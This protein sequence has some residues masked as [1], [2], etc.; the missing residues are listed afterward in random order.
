MIEIFAGAAVLCSVAKQLGMKNS[1]AVDKVKKQNACSTIYQLDLLSDRDRQLL[2]QW[3][4]SGLLLWIHLAP[5]CGTASRARDI[6]RFHNDPK[7]L[8]S[9]DWPEGL[10][11]LS[12]KELER[13]SLANR[14][15]EAACDFFLLA[16]SRGVLVTMENPKNSYFW[17]TKW[18]Q[19]LISSVRTFTADFQVCMMGG[20][21]DKWTRLLAN[22]GEIS[23]MNIA[24]DKSHQHAPWGFAFDSEGR[25][26]WATALESQYPKKMCVVLTSIVLEVAASRGLE[27]QAS[28]LSSDKNPLASAVQAQMS[29]DRQPKPSRVPPIV[30]DFSSVAIFLADDVS[31]LPCT[32]MSKLKNPIQLFTHGGQLQDVPANSRLLRISA[33]PELS[34]GG[35][36]EA[37]VEGDGNKKRKVH[38][39]HPLEVAF[40]LPWTWESF[41]DKAVHSHHPFVQGTGVPVELQEAI[42]KHVEWNDVQLCKYR[43]DWCKKWL[44]RAKQL[45]NMEKESNL[46]RPPHVAE[47]TKGKRVLLTKEI[48]EELGYDDLGVLSLLEVGATLAGEIEQTKIFQAQ[49]KPCLIAME[50]L[51]VESERRNDFILNLTKSS[52]EPQ[53]DEKLLAETKEELEC[54]WAEGPVLRSSLEHGAIISRRF[55][56]V[57]GAKTRMIDDFSISGINDSCIIHNKIDLHLIDTFAA[58]IKSFFVQCKHHNVCGA[59]VGKTYD[60]KSAYRQVPIRSDHLKFAYFSIY[61][62]ESDEV[63]IYRLKTLPFGAT[64]SVY[65]FLRLAR[66]LY[67]IMVRGLF[68]MTNFYDDF[69]LASPPQLQESASRGM[70]LVFLLTGWIY[71]KEGKKATVFD[72]ACKALGV[73]FNFDRSSDF[74]MHVENTEARKKEICDLIGAALECGRLG[75]AESLILRG[76]L[77]FAD[78]FVHGRLGTLTLKKL[79][80]HAYGRTSKLGSDTMA[81][82][83][84]MSLRLKVAGP[85]VVTSTPSRCWHIFTDAAYEQSTQTGGLGG[86]LFDDK[87]LACS[88]FSVE[89]TGAASRK[90]GS[91]F[92][93][94]LI[95]ELEMAASIV[96]MQLWGRDSGSNLH[97]CYG[98]NDSARFSLIR[99]SGSGEVACLM[100]GKFLTWEAENNVVT[101][102]ARVPTEANIAD[103]PSRFHK[104][105]ILNDDISCNGSATTVFQALIQGIDVGMPL[106]EKG[107]IKVASPI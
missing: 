50:Q 38:N 69:I 104:V 17:W 77:G 65:N 47:V 67:T 23:A 19:R 84:A 26:V 33:N 71:A 64:H 52:G 24:C 75:K 78:S 9:E 3:M 28:Q 82:L 36:V 66:M 13:V 103:F 107:S 74:L 83:Q 29:S 34:K 2:E 10:P 39:C 92:K 96:A 76:K 35:V 106:V 87:G 57:Q 27:L 98:D 22:F 55:A 100:L 44:I 45:D 18:V 31:T 25:Q 42:N 91:G 6:R 86:V 70:E 54:G 21:R 14:L 88:W 89:V 61:K 40:G 94:S 85:R 79:S 56:L 59:L 58:T 51:Q 105:E 72:S 12:P 1:I 43:L 49:F 32:I 80:E 20:D 101:W 93:Q 11:G 99:A 81:A 16:C 60:L 95:Y 102:F 53:L 68:L 48:L 41:V 73:Q 5:V 15:F 97:V 62:C 30:P 63:Q 8:R 90:L 37:Q 46:S 7:P 4:H